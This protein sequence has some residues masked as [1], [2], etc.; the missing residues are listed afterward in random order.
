MQKEVNDK[1]TMMDST[2][3]TVHEGQTLNDKNIQLLMKKMDILGEKMKMM[4]QH[5]EETMPSAKDAHKIAEVK[6]SGSPQRK[7]SLSIITYKDTQEL[8][9]DWDEN[10]A[11]STEAFDTIMTDAETKKRT[12]AVDVAKTTKPKKTRSPTKPITRARLGRGA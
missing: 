2:I 8:E 10:F 4:H 11:E 6:E 9:E 1:L 7:R 12:A 5:K 3:R